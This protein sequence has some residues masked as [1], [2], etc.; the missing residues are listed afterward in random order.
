MDFVDEIR[1]IT[2]DGVDVVFD[3]IGGPHLWRSYRALWSDSTVI[4]FGHATSHI[5]GT[6][7]GGKRSRLR[8][9]PTI[10][11][12]IIAS[13]LIPN[14]KRIVLYSI[15]TL[16]KRKPG[17]FREDIGILFDLL[18]QG[19]IKPIIAERIPLEQAARAHEM[20]SRGSVIGR[21]VLMCE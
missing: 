11:G 9:L 7:T 8:G 6:L 2:G 12:Y 1:R 5:S 15:Q 3:A 10:A 14:N 4:A 18:S 16:K 13:H 21:I 19:K 20:L 17:W